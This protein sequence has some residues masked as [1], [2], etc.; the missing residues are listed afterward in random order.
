MKLA[1]WTSIPLTLNTSTKPPGTPIF[2]KPSI[3]PLLTHSAIRPHKNK[4]LGIGKPSKYLALPVVSW[5]TKATVAL[6]LARRA[7]PAQMKV[8]KR[9]VS[10]VVRSP[11]QNAATAGATPN[12][13]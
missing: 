10:V 5:G 4:E 13:I 11:I 12:D 6:N 2:P 7:I 9:K 3:L 1:Q 8:V